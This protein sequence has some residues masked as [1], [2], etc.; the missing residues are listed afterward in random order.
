MR[1]FGDVY[2][3]TG[4]RWTILYWKAVAASVA[5]IV[6]SLILYLVSVEGA[7]SYPILCGQVLPAV[8]SVVMTSG[9]FAVIYEIFVRRGQTEFILE[10]LEL[11]ESTI[12]AGLEGLT[13]NY[14]DYD[15]RKQIMA[16]H[17]II[18]FVLYAQTWLNRY[19][20]EIAAHVEDGRSLTF[21]APALDNP[22]LAPLAKHFQ[23][24]EEELKRR[25]SEAVTTCALFALSRSGEKTGT[26]RIYLH[27][28]RPAY[29]MYRFDDRLL[30]GTYYASSARR[31]APMFEFINRPGSLFSDFDA[32]L[33]KVVN[34]DAELI[35]DSS[36]STN[37]IIEK[38][39][40]FVPDSFQ[41][42]VER[43][44]RS[45]PLQSKAEAT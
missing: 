39:A 37:Q 5:L 33:L 38:L 26:V 11:R 4:L 6:V 1:H 14:M 31:R 22:F 36:N 2:G 34:D 13:T 45:A 21:C 19:S 32:D 41:R 43:R 42:A 10:A 23:Y 20:S 3:K 25:I 28:A 18:L 17:H 29:S 35:F 12:Q 7:K 24:T 30:V 40:G 44:T 8:A 9:V 27:R 15:Y 16:T